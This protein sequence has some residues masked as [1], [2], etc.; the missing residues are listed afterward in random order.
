MDTPTTVE[1]G[2]CHGGMNRFTFWHC[3]HCDAAT[4]DAFQ[5]PIAREENLEVD[6]P[7]EGLFHQELNGA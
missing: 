4:V 3:D 6:G 5:G 7:H 2:K 1:C